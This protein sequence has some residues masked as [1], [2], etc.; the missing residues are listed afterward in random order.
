ML[1]TGYTK[2]TNQNKNRSIR[3]QYIVKCYTEGVPQ[4]KQYHCFFHG[5][6]KSSS[7]KDFYTRTLSEY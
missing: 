4:K 2:M 1:C 6:P 5:A 3:T 7:K